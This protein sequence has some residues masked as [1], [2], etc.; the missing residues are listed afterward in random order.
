MA[1]ICTKFYIYCVLRDKVGMV[2]VSDATLC[3]GPSKELL[4]FLL[5]IAV[6]KSCPG[7]R[8]LAG[9]LWNLCGRAV[10]GS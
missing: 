5:G 7:F 10:D 4:L 1:S 2:Y 6:A 8:V 3:A 9:E